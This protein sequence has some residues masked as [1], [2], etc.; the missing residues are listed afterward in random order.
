MRTEHCTR[1]TPGGGNWLAILALVAASGGAMHAADNNWG[2]WGRDDQRGTLNYIT[3]EGIKGAAA[4]PKR[5]VVFSLALPIGSGQPGPERAA[6]LFAMKT[7]QHVSREPGSLSEVIMLPTQATTHWNG[8][9]HVFGDGTIYNGYGAEASTTS[10]GAQKNGIEHAAGRVVSRGVLLD[11][12]RYKDMKHLAAGYTVTREDLEATARR[13][14]ISPRAGDIIL[15]RTGWISTFDRRDPEKFRAAQ[16]GL[17]WGAARW[18][19]EIRA[20][21]VAV[22]NMNAEVAPADREAAQAIGHPDFAQPVTYELVRNQG[23]LVGQLFSLEALAADCAQDGVY[24]F[25]FAASPLR[26]NGGVS[27]PINPIAVK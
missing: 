7:G 10:A 6:Q 5:G 26:F 3:A 12:A 21:A 27:C 19:K 23:M 24:E 4:L 17:G 16:P 18:L 25:F 8:L 22:D 15:V 1:R 20:A 14:K 11:V 13:Q 9:A 2:K